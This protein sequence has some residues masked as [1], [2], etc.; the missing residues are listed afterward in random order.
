MTLFSGQSLTCVRGGRT[1]FANLSFALEAGEALV[2]L[3]PNGSGKSSL[4]RLMALLLRP[5]AGQL[6]WQ[7]ESAAADPEAHGAR[8]HYVG[9]HDA[10]KPVLTVQETLGF[11][12]RLHG[13]GAAERVRAALEAFDLVRLADAPGRL[14]SAGQKRRTNLARLIAAPAPL[15]LLDEPTTA[16]DKASIQRLEAAIARHRAEGGIVVVSTHAE[17]SLP[18]GRDL[19][20]DD[21]PALAFADEAA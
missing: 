20:L 10:V 19:H 11:W 2:L 7:G 15:W 6:F 5:A 4:L 8:L 16:L 13:G 1:V 18:G 14:L 21:F 3:G 17:I 9:H 12:A